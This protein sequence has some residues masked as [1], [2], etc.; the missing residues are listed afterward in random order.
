M[1]TVLNIVTWAV[2]FLPITG[3][4]ALKAAIALARRTGRLS[5]TLARIDTILH[6]S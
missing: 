4:L 3:F 1:L 5:G 6:G 2:V